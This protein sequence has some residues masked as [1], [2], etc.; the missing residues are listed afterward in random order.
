M[1]G[2]LASQLHAVTTSVSATVG[3]AARNLATG[4]EIHINSDLFFP[5]ASTFKVP[6]LLELLR[7]AELGRIDL[8]QRL[9]LPPDNRVFG[10]GVLKELDAGL[11][12]TVRD[13]ALLMII[14]SDNLATDMLA[15]LVGLENVNRTLRAH[16]LKDINVVLTCAQILTRAAGIASDHPT[17]AELEQAR[18]RLEEADDLGPDNPALSEGLDN[19]V[20]TPR[21]FAS[22]LGMVAEGRYVSRRVCDQALEIMKKQQLRQRIPLLLPSGVKVANKTGTLG[23]VRNDVGLIFGRRATV[24]LAVFTKKALD[25]I[26]TDRVI[27]ECARLVFEGWAA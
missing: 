6:L 15:G 3:L 7:Q 25:P 20:A 26:A 2:E 9:E 21:A 27:A 14:V 12:P 18:Q 1:G 13:L 19:N 16:G 8:E 23:P 4:E 10:S 11:R 17:P 22:L 24:A 5:M